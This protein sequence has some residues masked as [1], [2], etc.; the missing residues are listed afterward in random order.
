MGPGQRMLL[1][2]LLPKVSQSIPVRGACLP[3]QLSTPSTGDS[4]SKTWWPLATVG[5]LS[6][7]CISFITEV[8]GTWWGGFTKQCGWGLPHV[9]S[10]GCDH[11]HRLEELSPDQEKPGLKI[12]RAF[13]IYLEGLPPQSS[14]R[15]L[16]Q[17]RHPCA[18]LGWFC[19]D[20]RAQ[21]CLDLSSPPSMC[22]SSCRQRHPQG[23]AVQRQAHR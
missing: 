8:R 20:R 21:S 5:S 4:C 1:F 9:P 11:W 14:R 12:M 17:D 22:P 3:T 13:C 15:A 18:D 6:P 2:P 23:P 10:W 16:A 19:Q 7:A